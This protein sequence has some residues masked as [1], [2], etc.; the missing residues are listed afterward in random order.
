MAESIN[1]AARNR[2]ADSVGDDFNLATMS[3]GSGAA[4]AV[5]AALTG[6]LAS[7]TLPADAMAAAASGTAAKSGT[8]SLTISGAG[9]ASYFR[10][11]S[12]AGDRRYQ[13]SI[14]ATGGGGDLEMATVAIPAA[15]TVTIDS[16]SVTQPAS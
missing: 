15:G 4:P 14:T 5:S 8:W 11:V 9:N 16:F 10:I 13:G 6:V 7:G 1:D 12:A 3:I 2:Q